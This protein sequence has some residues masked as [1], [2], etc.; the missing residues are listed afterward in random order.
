[1]LPRRLQQVYGP[2]RVRLDIQQGDL[3]RFL[4]GRLRRAVD[5]QVKAVRPKHFFN[6]RTVANIQRRVCEPLGD[7]LQP[8]QIPKRVAC[9]AEENP[10]HVVVHADNFMSLPVEMLH[11]LRTDQPAAACDKNPHPFES[12]PLFK[13]C[14]PSPNNC[15]EIQCAQA[16][17]SRT[18]GPLAP[19]T[20]T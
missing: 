4:V 2:W 14:E 15:R 1:M 11:S 13:S 10:S 7:T 20:I 5:Y 6:G 8:L 12:V 17:Q 18:K 3:P 9:R 16:L 19:S